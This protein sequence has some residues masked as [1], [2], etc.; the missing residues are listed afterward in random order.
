[1]HFKTIKN[2]LLASIV[3]FLVA[4]PL[5]LGISLATG[6]SLFSGI[7]SGIIGGI[8]VGFLSDSPLSVSG[9]AAGM[10]AVVV[11]TIS[12]LG[13]YE[14]FL[15]ALAVAGL[16]Q[17]LS[18][19]FRLG[20]VADFVPTNVIQGLL[21]AV[22]ILII[23]KQLALAVGYSPDLNTLK[24]AEESWQFSAIY[25]ILQDINLGACIIAFVS[26]M[27]LIFWEKL[28]PKLSKI[29]PAAVF[30]I[31]VS[32]SLN[33]LF[34]L[35]IPELYLNS[36]HLV[37]IPVSE[38]LKQFIGQFQ[39]P[40]FSAFK[41]L[42]V[43]IYA[44][45]LA[46]V[47]S[48]ESLLNLEAVEKLDSKHRYCSR[49]KELIAQGAG[50]L[51]AG[52]LGGL[53]ITSVI[54]RSSVNINAGANSKVS[55]ISH[56]FL[57]LLSLTLIAQWLNYIPIPA[58]ATIL[59]YTGY[60][61]AKP[62]VFQA[63]Y[64]EGLRYFLPFL[65]TIIAIVFT[66][67]L[68]GIIVGLVISLLFILYNNSQSG[69]TAVDELHPSGELLRLILPQQVTFLNKAAI[70]E[71]LNRIPPYAK[72]IIDA[73]ST[74]Y[75]DIDILGVI[76]DFQSFQAPDKKILL[77]LEGFKSHY[78]IKNQVKFIHATTY[79]VQTALE[80]DMVL[81]ILKEG[82]KRFVKNTPIHRDYKQ[83]IIATSA[84]QH[85]V[86]VILSCIDSRVPVELIFDMSIGD[87]FVTRVAGNVANLDILGSIEFACQVAGAKLI[88]V[89]G[90]KQC[91]AIKAACDHV[92]LGHLT[93]LVDKIKPAIQMETETVS[94]RTSQ[95]EIFLD[96]I[97]RN[98][99]NVAK[100]Y[101]FEQSE[102]LKTLINNKKIGLVG[103]IYDIHTG[104]VEFQEELK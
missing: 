11:A 46:M 13:S 31:L 76:M 3:V 21:A 87:V 9:P 49:N 38:N 71:E 66:S 6:A 81:T 103:G 85:P 88:V 41:N 26:L 42:D 101:L 91:G 97:I 14:A 58:L 10:I 79:D 53:P 32:I 5:C 94:D 72:V 80:P 36:L 63:A 57:L 100:N 40:D 48:L 59:I 84:S 77:N 62:A 69:F 68:I 25:S 23:I 75:I 34:K 24:T 99:V 56:G 16:L 45:V 30:V 47:A 102:I 37:N 96:N 82:N 52:L 18:G 95:N 20:F 1:M 7:L 86:A 104:I 70:V 93:Q 22:G 55:T 73:K 19:V 28:L 92:Q 8:I 43:Y 27:I 39:H 44:V 67:L 35:F 12:Q 54:V 89:L 33:Q 83:K 51:V 17:M 64:R 90:H 65:V 2:D 50:N 61:L 60:K 4:V 78:A 98:N 74:D 29:L 15:L